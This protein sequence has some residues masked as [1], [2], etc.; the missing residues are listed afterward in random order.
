MCLVLLLPVAIF[1]LTEFIDFRKSGYETWNEY[2]IE[3]IKYAIDLLQA[4]G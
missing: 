2:A 1:S 3:E 4:Y